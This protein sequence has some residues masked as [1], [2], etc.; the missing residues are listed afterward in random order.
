MLHP[1]SNAVNRCMSLRRLVCYLLDVTEFGWERLNANDWSLGSILIPDDVTSCIVGET[2]V[3]A[4]WPE[5]VE[6]MGVETGSWRWWPLVCDGTDVGADFEWGDVVVGCFGLSRRLGRE[7]NFGMS[8]NN[9]TV[10]WCPLWSQA[11]RGSNS[12]EPWHLLL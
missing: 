2:I 1:N 3:A 5:A 9:P 10:K 4:I 12:V 8:W 11:P 6:S 7:I